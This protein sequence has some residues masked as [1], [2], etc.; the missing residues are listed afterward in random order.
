M[1]EKLE[2]W[3]KFDPND[4]DPVTKVLTNHGN[5]SSDITGDAVFN[6]YTA[7]DTTVEGPVIADYFKE[8]GNVIP[9]AFYNPNEGNS[10]G[11]PAITLPDITL[12]EKKEFTLSFWH[13]QSSFSSAYDLFNIRRDT[14]DTGEYF[15]VSINSSEYKMIMGGGP[16]THTFTSTQFNNNTSTY[17]NNEWYHHCFT[18]QWYD[19]G[20]Q[21]DN[22]RHWVIRYYINGVIVNEVVEGYPWE[23]ADDRTSFIEITFLKK[24]IGSN[25]NHFNGYINDFRF[26]TRALTLGE[27]RTLGYVLPNIKPTNVVSLRK[28]GIIK[29][30]W[31]EPTD[32]V[33]Q[34][35]I[36]YVDETSATQTATVNTNSFS[37][38]GASDTHIYDVTV[39]ANNSLALE[40]ADDDNIMPYLFSAGYDNS[41][42]VI[43]SGA[44]A[45]D[46]TTRAN[47]R[48]LYE[49]M[50]NAG[51]F[52][53]YYKDIVF[54]KNTTPNYNPLLS[55]PTLGVT[56]NGQAV[57]DGG[58]YRPIL[59]T[60]KKDGTNSLIMMLTILGQ[61]INYHIPDIYTVTNKN[62]YDGTDYY[63]NVYNDNYKKFDIILSF[64][65]NIVTVIING[66]SRTF[67]R[68]HADNNG[69]VVPPTSILLEPG[70]APDRLNLFHRNNTDTPQSDTNFFNHFDSIG[71]VKFYT[72]YVDSVPGLGATASTAKTV[73][74]PESLPT[75][76]PPFPKRIA[77]ADNVVSLSKL[78]EDDLTDPAIVGS[79]LT[80][81]R[82]T[83]KN[84]IKDFMKGFKSTIGSNKLKLSKDVTLPGYS[85]ARDVFVFNAAQ[86]ETDLSDSLVSEIS[87]A[88]A[89]G[90]DFYVVM[91]NSDTIT[92]PSHDD[93][94]QIVKN[95]DNT[96]TLTNS[97]GDITKPANSIYQYN[98]LTLNLGSV[99]GH[100]TDII[101]FR[102][103]TKVLCYNEETQVEYEKTIESIKPGMYLKTY[104]HGYKK[105]E[106]MN[107]REIC[108]PGDDERSKNRLYKLEPAQ[109]PELKETLYLT[110]CHALL[111]DKLNEEQTTQVKDTLGEIYI[112]DDKYRLPA[113]YDPKAEPF[114]DENKHT[115]W[116]VCLEH[117]DQEMNYGI[118]VNGGLLTESCCKRNILLFNEE[119]KK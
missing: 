18:Y 60:L 70:N 61:D 46:V 75:I 108:N 38:T 13:K 117:E 119:M 25:T 102:E 81:K 28:Q 2:L 41:T 1:D 26:Y 27:V 71:S 7:A 32:P 20:G 83:S 44:I 54:K 31:D 111:V 35:D 29:F 90:K 76:F 84:L 101:C 82:A 6:V 69:K 50:V 15:K 91:D 94:V 115:V 33:N 85:L 4:V 19:Y 116:H 79:T 36:T 78:S 74:V 21:S 14:N 73:T 57:G 17:R 88:D 5:P 77:T 58:N 92:I 72:K 59:I 10:V 53:I 51:E 66:V 45:T 97:L 105:V 49:R 48:T 98:G 55:I 68:T 56:H 96:Y 109:Y 8:E 24:M 11:K 67:S 113:M 30:S 43:T 86:G 65:D 16:T 34:Y 93:T 42:G 40:N 100:L 89:F 62:T 114:A 112:T 87:Y 95:T 47:A 104:K 37:I 110:G 9:G 3:Y 39:T 103:G 99:L 107:S 12:R 106:L 80:D 63:P 118:Y 64:K 22:W 23:S 52:T